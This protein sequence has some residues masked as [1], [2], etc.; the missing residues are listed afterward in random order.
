MVVG[1]KDG[2]KLVGIS[3]VCFCAVYVCTFMLNYYLDVVPL[4]EL[5]DGEP[6]LAL[7]EAQL[8]IARFTSLITGG[9][10]GATALVMLMFYVKLYIDKSSVVL[11]VIK[12]LGYSRVRIALKFWVFGLS[13]F[14]GCFLGFGVGWASMQYIY[15]G[16]TIEGMGEITP[17]FHAIIPIVL[18]LAPTLAFTLL[19]CVYS[20][21]YLKK[22]AIELL[23]GKGVE[24]VRKIR[25]GSSSKSFLGDMIVCTLKS[26]KSL[27]FFVAFSCFCFSSMV[28]MGLSMENLVTTSMGYMIL[29]IGL[30]LASVSMFMA[31]T[32]LVSSNAKNLSIMKA[33]GYSLRERMFAVFGGYAP[34][35]ALGFALGTVYQ[36]ALLKVMINIIFSGVE[37]IPE[38]NFDIP[39]FFITLAVFTLACMLFMGYYTYRVNKISAKEIMTE[40]R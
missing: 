13:V 19:A 17:T 24:K 32:S 2:I 36:F 33:F 4:G 20:Y 38:Y 29:M 18:V 11:G 39:V 35:A 12:A 28:Q 31:I 37:N 8:A 22:P 15:N 23:R 16:L 34:F 14:I 1:F 9:V 27:V 30:V 7:Y 21:F 40:N 25:S 10:L 3:I 26:R 5:F 6:T